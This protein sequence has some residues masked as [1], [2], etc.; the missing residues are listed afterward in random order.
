MGDQKDTRMVRGETNTSSLSLCHDNTG[1][2]VFQKGGCVGLPPTKG[3]A[4]GDGTEEKTASRLQVSRGAFR[5][6]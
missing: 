1:A 2:G 5:V 6:F 4:A 3:K